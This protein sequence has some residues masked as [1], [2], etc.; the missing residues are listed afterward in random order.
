MKKI[1]IILTLALLT[2]QLY[3]KTEKVEFVKNYNHLFN[4]NQETKFVLSNKYGDI[5]IKNWT[6]HEVKI[7]VKITVNAKTQEK[8]DKVFKTIKINFSEAKDLISAI[9]EIEE[10]SKFFVVETGDSYKIDYDIYLPVYLQI[11]LKNKYG[12]T[13]VSE[14]HSRSNFEIKYGDLKADNLVFP[15]T[16]PYSKI[17]IKYGDVDIKKISWCTIISKYSDIKIDNSTAL[18]MLSKYSEYTIGE[19]VAIVTDSKYDEFKINSTGNFVLTGSYTDVDIKELSSQFVIDAK[20]GSIKVGKIS[21]KLQKVRIVAD[22]TDVNLK[23]SKESE[24]IINGTA[25]YGELNFGNISTIN[26]TEDV[27]KSTVKGYCN[28]EA[29]KNKFTFSIKYGDINLIVE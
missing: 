18:L 25:N 5:N 19:N 24:F 15:D 26:I 17:N 10:N 11:D 2:T 6:K 27:T 21:E 28:N 1:I 4:V 16:K 13:F 12:N 14:L 29:S 7:D 8:A 20:Y 22:Y 9:T 23:V 3:A